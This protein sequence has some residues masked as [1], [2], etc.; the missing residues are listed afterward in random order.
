MSKAKYERMSRLSSSMGEYNDCVPKAIALAARIPY[1]EAL[2]ICAL[3]GRRKGRGV[4]TE[5]ALQV[6]ELKHPTIRV[7]VTR[8]EQPN[9]SRYTM[10]TI[11]KVCQRGYYI[12]VVDG[13]AAAVI[14]GEVCDWTEG[15][16]NRVKR[17]YRITKTR[18]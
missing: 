6:L 17:L 11:G 3:A 13:H 18:T 4:S 8:P 16:R 15:R 14:N 1:S 2:A 7:D 9:G 5:T 12:A 10:T